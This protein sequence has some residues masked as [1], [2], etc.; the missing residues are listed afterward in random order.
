MRPRVSRLRSE[1]AVLC[2]AS[3]F[4]AWSCR[5]KLAGLGAAAGRPVLEMMSTTGHKNADFDREFLTEFG[6]RNGIETEYLSNVQSMDGQLAVYRKL[7]KA[8]SA[9]PDLLQ[10]D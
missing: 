6:Q 4:C 9:K 1:L 7:L 2:L 10:V 8:H 3:T 5:P